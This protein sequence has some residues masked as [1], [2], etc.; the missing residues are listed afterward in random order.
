MKYQLP[1]NHGLTQL[2]QDNFLFYEDGNL[3]LTNAQ[4]FSLEEGLA[5]GQSQLIVSPTST[6]KTQIAVWGMA[7]AIQQGKKCVYLVTHRALARQKFEDFRQIYNSTLFNNDQSAIVLA[8]G[9][10][11]VDGNGEAPA[12][13][14]AA[15]VV[16][17]TYEKYLAMIAAAGVPSS[18]ANI[19]FVCDEVQLL[20]DKHRGTN[21]EIL[22]T[23]LKNAGWYQFLGL[24]AVLDDSDA[25]EL[26]NWL[27]IK[28]IKAPEREKNLIYECWTPGGIFS[29]STAVLS[30]EIVQSDL[31]IG[32]VNTINI[33]EYLL[34]NNKASFP[35]IVFCMRK[36]DIYDLAALYEN[37]FFP[38]SAQQFSLAFEN[39]PVTKANTDLTRYLP[40]RFAIHC[41]DLTDEEREVVESSLLDGSVDVVFSTS[42]LAAGVNFPLG[43]AVFHAWK[44]W[45]MDQ[46]QYVPIEPSEFHNMSGRVGRMGTDHEEGRVI[47]SLD[48][49]HEF[50]TVGRYFEFDKYATFPVNL[51][52]V[53]F[54][55]VILQLV[56]AGIA[57]SKKNIANLLK[58]TFSGLKTEDNNLAEFNNWDQYIENA[59]EWNKLNG[60]LLV[61]QTENILATPL[62]RSV[63]QSGLLVETAQFLLAYFLSDKGKEFIQFYLNSDS[64]DIFNI[65]DFVLLYLFL[66]SPEFH[67]SDDTPK[68]RFLP[69][70]LD[71]GFIDPPHLE[72]VGYLVGREWKYHAPAITNSVALARQWM[73]GKKISEI[74]LLMK[75]LS[76]GAIFELFRNLRWLIQGAAQILSVLTDKKNLHS[77][78][79]SGIPADENTITSLRSIVRHIYG[80]SSRLSAGV[81]SDVMWMLELNR[82]D[83]GKVTRDEIN[84]LRRRGII[85]IEDA[86]RGD[87]EVEAIRVAVFKNAKPA[88]QVKSSWFRDKSRD[89]K[90]AQ[91]DKARERQGARAQNCPQNQLVGGFYDSLGNDFESVFEDI[92]NYLEVSFELVDKQ[93]AIGAPDYL[94]KFSDDQSIVFELKS[95]QNDK[96]VDYNGATEVLAASEIH[97]FGDKFCVTLCHPGVDP[98][99]PPVISRCNRLSVIES[100][101][102]GEA[103]LRVCEG[104]LSLSQFYEW[105]TRP[106]QAL[107]GDLPYGVKEVVI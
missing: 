45:D 86:M 5:H 97:G 58:T 29:K 76:A 70:Q 65:V 32:K 71:D 55:Q 19:L 30:S 87:P 52:G 85:K 2:I 9:D 39:L 93:G 94:V 101:D 22:I 69:W 88:P 10:L 92:L 23:L 33:I 41:A 63:A 79:I 73:L 51:S 72:A 11:I 48:A 42:T 36:K 13:P 89:L 4:Y 18:M 17:A 38:N 99:V 57:N 44:R 90:K 98:S 56:S 83:G 80:L 27:N 49:Q 40:N 67:G 54:K 106:G 62:G 20:G 15:P 77:L 74:E 102:L 26:C 68:T 31:P 43:M 34:K 105:L 64:E 12:D 75:D 37:K 84:E 21:V 81:P 59:I 91:R 1:Q 104:K 7:E 24:S 103:L 46:R 100:V 3:Q 53:E 95:K 107:R 25:D 50:T 60:I 82:F 8:T 96:N 78:Q 35:I 28:K 61:D 47:F 16:V 6:G 66:Y 14:L